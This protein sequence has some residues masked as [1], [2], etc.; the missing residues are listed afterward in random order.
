[1]KVGDIVRYNTAVTLNVTGVIIG[2]N[3]KGEGGQHYAHILRDNG[4]I[5]IRMSHILE[6]IEPE[7]KNGAANTRKR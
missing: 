2:F 7:D 3:E 1:M 4:D 6:V 5:E